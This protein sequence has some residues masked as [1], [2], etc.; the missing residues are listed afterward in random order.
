MALGKGWLKIR[1]FNLLLAVADQVIKAIVSDFFCP[2]LGVV[3][4]KTLLIPIDYQAI[5]SLLARVG[6]I[7]CP[8]AAVIVLT[9]NLHIWVMILRNSY[10]FS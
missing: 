8:I 3:V 1:M 2:D 10:N 9:K 5:K 6:G 4:H 7:F